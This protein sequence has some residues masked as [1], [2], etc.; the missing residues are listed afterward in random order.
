MQGRTKANRKTLGAKLPLV[1]AHK[2]TFGSDA[3]LPGLQQ[4]RFTGAERG[5][6]VR[7]LQSAIRNRITAPR[8]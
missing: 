2:L 5:F 6:L 8:T 1:L 3:A 4:V 7:N